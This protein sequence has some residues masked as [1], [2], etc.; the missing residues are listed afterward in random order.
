[1]NSGICKESDKKELPKFHLSCNGKNKISLQTEGVGRSVYHC[2]G[3][4]HT[5]VSVINVTNA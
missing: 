1:M 5:L 3:S 2:C 4:E